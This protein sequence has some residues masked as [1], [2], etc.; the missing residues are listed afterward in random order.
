MKTPQKTSRRRKEAITAWGK[1]VDG[2]QA[3]LASRMRHTYRH[4]EMVKLAVKLRNVG[5]AE[6]KVTYGLLRESR[7][8][9]HRCR[10]RAGERL[11]AAAARG[12]RSRSRNGAQARRDDHPVQPGDRG[13]VQECRGCSG[14]CGWTTPTICVVPG[15][16]KIAF[17]GMIQSH[18]KLTTGTVEIRGEG[19]NRR[20]S[21]GLHRLGQGGRWPAGGPVHRQP[22]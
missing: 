22:E 5:K 15:K 19:A 7:P 21:G 3:G 14:R 8:G 10:G 1:E 6:V 13:G 9:C 11:H 12:T 18:P 16:Y 17:G 20:G 4:G 2:L